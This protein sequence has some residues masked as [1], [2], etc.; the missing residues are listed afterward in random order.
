MAASSPFRTSLHRP[1]EAGVRSAWEALVARSP[2]ATAFADLALL[3]VVQDALG[4]TPRLAT[5]WEDDALR[6]G[7]LVFEKRWGPLRIAVL[8]PFVQYVSPLLDGPLREADV[9]A[10]RSPLD[11]LAELLSTSFDQAS[12]VLHPS[13]EDVRALQW[14]GWQL[15]PAST[16]HV[17]LG[18]SPTKGWSSNPKRTLKSEGDQY[19]IETGAEGIDALCDLVLASHDRQGQSVGAAPE[20]LR[21]MM[22]GATGAGLTRILVARRDGVPEAGLA[23]LTDGRTAHYWLAGS[24]P[25][26]AMTVLLAG[27]FTRLAAEGVTTFDFAGANT[28]SIAEFKRRFGGV[29]VPYFRARYTRHGV[30]RLLNR[31]RPPL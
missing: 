11:A 25:G 27:A 18:A 2:Q 21:R 22:Q 20:A 9:H 17:T 3:P 10:H 1:D 24:V 13:L 28:P 14:G 7:A 16:Y 5:V 19:E 6:A 4:L 15:K 8:P 31:L 26:A 29:L 12:L 23:V 30:L